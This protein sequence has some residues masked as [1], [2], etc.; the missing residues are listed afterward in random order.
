MVAPFVASSN[1]AAPRVATTA[2]DV[3]QHRL[4]GRSNVMGLIGPQIILAQA[5]G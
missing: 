3:L 5:I 4:Y 1:G 2:G